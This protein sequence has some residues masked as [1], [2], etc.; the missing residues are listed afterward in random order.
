MNAA[1]ARPFA[2]P[3]LRSSPNFRISNREYALL[4]PLATRRKQTT[5]TRSNRKFLHGCIFRRIERA[6]ARRSWRDGSPLQ[7]SHAIGLP[8]RRL[9]HWNRSGGGQQGRWRG[10]LSDGWGLLRRERGHQRHCV[11]ARDREFVPVAL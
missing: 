4:E 8:A 3:A 2:T 1:A 9:V 7:A 11:I 6:R 10:I 5:A